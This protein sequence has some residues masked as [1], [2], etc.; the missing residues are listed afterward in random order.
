MGRFASWGVAVGVGL[1]FAGAGGSSRLAAQQPPAAEQKAA[2]PSALEL[3]PQE[4]DLWEHKVGPEAAIHVS[5]AEYAEV[6]NSRRSI[7]RDYVEFEIVVS[8]NGRVNSATVVKGMEIHV[9]EAQQIELARVF[10]PWMRDGR[11]VRVKL[12]DYVR[13]LPPERWADVEVPFPDPWDL[14]SVSVGLKRTSCYGSCPSYVVAIA[15]DGTVHFS[16]G[17]VGVRIPGEH[18]AHVAPGAVR[19]LVLEFRKADFFTAKNEYRGNWTDNP[20]QILTLAVAGRTK[21]VVDYVGTD[22]GLP[23]AIRNLEGEIDEVAGTAR[24]VKGDERTL[25]SLEEEK[26]P[27]G[28][29]T[30]QNVA[31]FATSISTKNGPLLERYMATAVPPI[32][33]PEE[34]DLSPVCVASAM[35]DLELVERMMEPAAAKGT[36]PE[37]VKIPAWAMQQ[38]LWSAARSGNVV[39]LQ[40]WLDAGANPMAQPAKNAADWTFGLSLLC[41]G[42]MS[43]NA[44]VVRRLLEYKMDL[45]AP[46]REDEPLLIFALERSG[47]NTPQTVEIVGMLAK[48]GADVNATGNMKETPIFAAHYSPEAIKPLLAAGAELEARDANGNTALIRY[49][50]MEPMVRELLEDG[51][52]PTLVAK[53]GDTAL[54]VAK[55]YHCPACAKSIEAALKHRAADGV[56]VPNTP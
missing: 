47:G 11:A 56:A 19:E 2:G 26:W 36:A 8:E 32:V 22:A 13:L 12:H 16:G 31:L 38:C 37:R 50:F 45:K 53:N 49:A 35:G 23:L 18:V 17:T 39:V 3:K 40:Y 4:V 20:T 33:A 9:D 41:N 7:G 6:I 42:V 52:D 21:T 43:G 30:K 34:T 46:V 25:S 55:Q 29:P 54:K 1:A 15:G 27:F 48:A 24:W 28:A 51:A 5:A 44:D 10:K 14:N